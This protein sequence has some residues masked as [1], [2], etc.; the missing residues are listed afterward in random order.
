CSLCQG[1]AL[2]ARGFSWT[3]TE[4]TA[5]TD[6]PLEGSG[7]EPSYRSYERVSRPLPNGNGRMGSLSTG[8][9]ARRR[10]LGRAPFPRPSAHPN[11][12]PLVPG[13]CPTP[14]A[15]SFDAQGRSSGRSNARQ[16]PVDACPVHPRSFRNL[17]LGDAFRGQ[18]AD[19]MG[20]VA[21]G[22]LSALVLAR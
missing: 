4:F 21:R 19:L 6:S 22:G 15:A 8:R 17:N 5:E 2:K 1:P 14:P 9:L 18:S 20:L 12:E 10:W 16:R 7:F 11:R 3:T 13:A